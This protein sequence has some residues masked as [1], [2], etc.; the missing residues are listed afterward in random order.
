MNL[1]EFTEYLVKSIVKEPD[2][3]KV[4]SFLG[5]ED[6]TMIEIIVHESDM[7]AVIGKNGKTASSIRTLV[8]AHAY[9]NGNK[10]VKI[11]IDSF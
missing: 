9:I 7:G 3:V 8:Q 1:V 11:N 10:K 2:M 6:V 5:D 4:S